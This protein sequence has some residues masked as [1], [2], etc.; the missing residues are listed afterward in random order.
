V[1]FRDKLA[2]AVVHNRS[3]L[4]VGLDPE[5][6]RL[7]AAVA[8]RDDGVL[9]FNR[10][11]V[12]ATC[13]LVC[14]YKPNFAF[15]GSLGSRGWAT[16]EATL[17]HIPSSV[18]TILDAKVSDIGNTA[19]HYARMAFDEL[20][21][22]ALTVNP[23]MG[24]DA[25][26]PF[27]ARRDKGVFLLCL[28]SN[29]GAADFETQAGADGPLYL[30]VAQQAQQWNQAGNAGLVVGAT[31]P[32]AFSELRALA[33]GMPFLVPGVGAQGGDLDAV[34]RHGRDTDGAGLVINASRAVL[35]TSGGEDF[36]GAA[37]RA[38][39]ELRA[40]IERCRATTG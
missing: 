24:R 5:P 14:A 11:I 10:R 31:R 7:P 35:Y 27:L 20:G 34:V 37:R 33:P 23:Y 6:A 28:T 36:A 12:D 17:S 39:E 1:T 30:R 16:L 40:A 29:P 19:E 3:L 18:P 25:V 4:C 8:G 15:Y 38:A 21:A 26:A 2:A 22:D 9:E 13:D 32:E